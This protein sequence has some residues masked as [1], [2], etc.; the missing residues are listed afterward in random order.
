MRSRFWV[1]SARRLYWLSPSERLRAS[2]PSWCLC[3]LILE[4]EFAR[5]NVPLLSFPSWGGTDSL[6]G[7]TLNT[8]YIFSSSIRLL[9]FLWLMWNCGGLVDQ[10]CFFSWCTIFKGAAIIK[11][12]TLRKKGVENVFTPKLQINFT[13]NYRETTGSTLGHILMI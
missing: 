2:A 13:S 6:K 9:L 8:G 12:C 3:A 10:F 11:K 5:A 4:L 7:H 1:I